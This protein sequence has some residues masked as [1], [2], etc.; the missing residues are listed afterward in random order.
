MIDLDLLMEKTIDFKIG[1]KVYRCPEPSPASYVKFFKDVQKGTEEE[2]NELGTLYVY[3]LLKSNVDGYTIEK[4]TVE[5]F[6]ARVLH[7]I[8]TAI[9]NT[10]NEVQQNPNFKSSR[11]SKK[12]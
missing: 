2:Q 12:K 3:E 1:G 11:T 4:E 7:A 9:G 8:M 5:Q 10:F 6:P